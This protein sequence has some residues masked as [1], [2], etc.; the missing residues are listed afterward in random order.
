MRRSSRFTCL[1]VKLSTTAVSRVEKAEPPKISEICDSG[2]FGRSD[3]DRGL[4]KN[5]SVYHQLTDSF[6][7][8][9]AL[10]YHD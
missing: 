7:D 10:Q 8:S 3:Q 6:Y 9:L 2:A 5:A 4:N 1:L